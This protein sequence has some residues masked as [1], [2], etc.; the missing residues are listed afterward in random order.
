MPIFES[1]FSFEDLAVEIDMARNG[2]DDYLDEDDEVP[3]SQQSQEGTAAEVPAPAEET[4]LLPSV[5]AAPVES[6]ECD[7]GDEQAYREQ[8]QAE[9]SA[10]TKAARAA[11]RASDAKYRCDSSNA[12]APLGQ[13]SAGPLVI[14]HNEDVA[15]KLDAL[16]SWYEKSKE[17]NA[18]WRVKGYRTAA[19][20]LRNAGRSIETF[21]DAVALPGI[22]EKTAVKLVEIVRTGRCT[23]LESKTP[24]EVIVEGLFTNIYGVGPSIANEWYNCGMRTLDDVKNSGKFGIILTEGQKLGVKHFKDL[25]ERIPRDE[26]TKVF[27]IIKETGKPGL[28]RAQIFSLIRY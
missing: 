17:H 26:A 1:P 23:K 9:K 6:D 13:T 15:S 8:K 3:E 20:A 18:W 5:R 7:S 11:K 2:L 4:V 24:K 22:G 21:E 14:R 10:I 25:Q 16:A 12:A 27:A 19:G 28:R